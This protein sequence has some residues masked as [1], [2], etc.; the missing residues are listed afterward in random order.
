MRQ[1]WPDPGAVDDVA[2]LVAAEE[3]PAPAD[4]PWVLVNMVAS[5]DGAIAVAGRSQGLGGPTD[6][7]MFAALRAVADVVLVGAGTVRAEGYGP[8][9]PSEATRAARRARGQTDAPRLAVVTRSLHLDLNAALFTKAEHPTLVITCASADAERQRAVAE[10]A[11]LVVAGDD[12]VDLADALRKLAQRGTALVT[13]EGGPTLNGALIAA[14]LVDEWD[15]TLSPLLTGSDED[16]AS[17]G[18]GPPAPQPMR[19]DR[20]IEGD[21]LLLTR[22]L[23]AR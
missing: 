12:A 4:R 9:R 2:V 23:R 13:C 3:R 19:L 20:L 1:L 10:R 21:G 14:D 11:E 8:A 16:R 5:L 15:L 18:P 22:W 7:A 17:R 6:K